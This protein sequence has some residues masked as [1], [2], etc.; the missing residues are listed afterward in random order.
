MLATYLPEILHTTGDRP[1]SR[2]ESLELLS[3]NYSTIVYQLF[4]LIV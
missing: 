4:E 1:I 2:Q 3:L